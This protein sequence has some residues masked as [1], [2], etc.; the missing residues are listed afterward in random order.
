MLNHF[1]TALFWLAAFTLAV[2]LWRRAQLW[3]AGKAAAWHWHQLFTVPKRY[4]V[5]LHHVVAREPYIA[6]THVATAGGAVAAL[7]LVAINYGLMLY[8]SWLNWAIVVATSIML[9]G[10]FFVWLR[11]TSM[12]ANQPPSRLSKG[13]WSRLP[14]SRSEERRVGKECA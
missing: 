3:R 9:I 8:S 5:D 13:N 7:G 6:N 12:I 10:V 14:Y 2:G 1:I 4:F 11:R